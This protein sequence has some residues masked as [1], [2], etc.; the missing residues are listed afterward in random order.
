ME[1]RMPMMIVDGP[2]AAGK[3][4]LI[5][6]FLALW[7]PER[8][9]TRA[10]GPVTSLHDYEGPLMNDLAEYAHDPL[11]MAVWDRSWASEWVYNSLLERG[12]TITINDL[13]TLERPCTDMGVFRLMLVPEPAVLSARRAERVE[14]GDNSDLPVNPQAEAGAFTY[15]ATEWHWSEIDTIDPE[16]LSQLFRSQYPP[17]PIIEI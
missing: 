9:F 4:T 13:S 6:S 1:P 2:E 3:T 8:R 7:A 14:K 12:R 5:T 16:T 11:R 10:W 15:Y 17:L